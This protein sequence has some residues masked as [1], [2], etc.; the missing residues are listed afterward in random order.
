[1]MATGLVLRDVPLLCGDEPPAVRGR[2][3]RWS[4]IHS[5]SYALSEAQVQA[6]KTKPAPG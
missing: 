4:E 1:M 5:C 6:F 2:A 3:P